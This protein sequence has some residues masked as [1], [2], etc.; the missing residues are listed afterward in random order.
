[1]KRD[2]IPLLLRNRGEIRRLPIFPAQLS[3]PDPS[4]DLENNRMPGLCSHFFAFPASE[5]PFTNAEL[6]PP[7]S[8]FLASNKPYSWMVFATSPVQPV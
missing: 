7:S 1:M 4:V 6:L 5:A 2:G 3:Q 8:A